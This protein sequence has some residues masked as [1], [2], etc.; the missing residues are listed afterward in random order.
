MDV[1]ARKHKFF[2]KDDTTLIDGEIFWQLGLST[3]VQLIHF[4]TNIILAIQI[5]AVMNPWR[6]TLGL[7]SKN[8]GQS[9]TTNRYH[10]I[11]LL[12]VE[13]V[14]DSWKVEHTITKHLKPAII[15]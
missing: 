13:E 4:Y 15:R 2:W 3:S 9:E 6:R 1:W 12:D 14:L 8:T 7:P 10:A 5:V 11:A